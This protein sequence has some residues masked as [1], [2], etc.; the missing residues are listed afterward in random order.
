[1]PSK[2]I[3]KSLRTKITSDAPLA[4]SLWWGSSVSNLKTECISICKLIIKSRGV[5]IIKSIQQA[6]LSYVSLE[7]GKGLQV[8]TLHEETH[9]I[10]SKIYAHNTVSE[11]H[12]NAPYI[13]MQLYTEY[14]IDVLNAVSLK[15]PSHKHRNQGTSVYLSYYKTS[16]KITYIEHKDIS[17]NCKA[18]I[19]FKCV[20]CVLVVLI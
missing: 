18:Y 17:F 9:I 19:P 10:S 2:L 8:R 6:F 20:V 14:V 12:Q 16:S 15:T 5:N 3:D 1:M 7:V 11:R 13:N 4:P